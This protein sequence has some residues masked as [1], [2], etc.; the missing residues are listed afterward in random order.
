VVR[1]AQGAGD[2]VVQPL[3]LPKHV[4][5]LAVGSPVSNVPEPEMVLL[6]VVAAMLL[7][8]GVACKRYGVKAIQR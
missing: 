7:A 6:L 4:S 1:N 5:N 3:P 2:D 8:A